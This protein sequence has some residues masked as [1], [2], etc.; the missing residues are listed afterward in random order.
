MTAH[1]VKAQVT[2]ITE[3]RGEALLLLEARTDEPFSAPSVLPALPSIVGELVPSP[4]IPSDEIGLGA[5]DGPGS[6]LGEMVD[7]MS[8]G[9]GPGEQP[10]STV[11]SS[12]GTSTSSPSILPARGAP[13][14]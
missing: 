5:A 3:L 9:A 11:K 8:P 14:R 2:R 13:P 12:V 1:T 6:A 4:G 10:H 7:V